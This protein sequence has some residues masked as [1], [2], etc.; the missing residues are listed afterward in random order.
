[1]SVE[2]YGICDS[3]LCV[4]R[5]NAVSKLVSVGLD[6]EVV[7]KFVR[8][9]RASPWNAVKLIQA[10]TPSYAKSC[11]EFDL[12][13]SVIEVTLKVEDSHAE[14]WMEAFGLLLTGSSPLF[15]HYEKLYDMVRQGSNEPPL[16]L[17]AIKLLKKMAIS[18]L[19]ICYLCPISSLSVPIPP[20]TLWPFHDSYTFIT[21]F[22]TDS[23]PAIS[24]LMR[25]RSS[26]NGFECYM[27]NNVLYYRTLIGKYQPPCIFIITISI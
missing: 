17:R 22:N 25:L 6:I 10:N 21:W 2:E 7:K 27:K 19:P 5:P 3:D 8:M 20:K 4:I 26:E 18:S 14:L 11:K 23:I 1:M 16:V 24:I 12:L 9:L 15:Q 13:S